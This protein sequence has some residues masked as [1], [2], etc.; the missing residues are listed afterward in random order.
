MNQKPRNPLV[1]AAKFRRAGHH[2]KSTKA[3]RR[4]ESTAL[5]HQLKKTSRNAYEVSL[6]VALLAAG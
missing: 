2:G 5:V 1:A 6:S 3:L 4:A